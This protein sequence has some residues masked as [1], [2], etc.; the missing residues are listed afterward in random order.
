[1]QKQNP[2][3]NLGDVYNHEGKNYFVVAK[4]SEDHGTHWYLY[5]N[6]VKGESWKNENTLKVLLT[7][8]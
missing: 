4:G 7:V 5:L 8:R 1:M 3:P 2:E 6:E